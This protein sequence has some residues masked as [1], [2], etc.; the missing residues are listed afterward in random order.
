MEK[1]FKR[2]TIVGCACV[3]TSRFTPQE[4][5]DYEHYCP[6]AMELKSEDGNIL[7]RIM[8]DEEGNPGKISDECAAFSS[9]NVPG[10]KATITLLLDPSAEDK[11]ELFRNKI[12]HAVMLLDRIECQMLEEANRILE[13]KQAIEELLK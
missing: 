8:L 7:Y 1:E 12:G 9:V 5:A 3:I 2:V 11:E 6:E 10:G 13:T 4:M